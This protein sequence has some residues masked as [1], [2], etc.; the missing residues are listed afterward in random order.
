[1]WYAWTEQ[2]CTVARLRYYESLLD[3]SER[4]RLARLAH[5]HLRHEYLLTR[6]LCRVSLSRYAGVAPAQWRFA[7]GRYGKPRIEWP[8]QQSL[9]FNL[10]NSRDLVACVVARDIDVGIDV[11]QIDR[12]VDQQEIA[13]SHFSATELRAF[14]ALAPERQRRRF[15]ELWTLKECYLKACGSGLSTALE[16]F[17]FDLDLNGA[18]TLTQDTS[19]T[20]PPAAW[21]FQLFSPDEQHVLAVGLRRPSG[22][23]W[24][25]HLCPT[26]P[27]DDAA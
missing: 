13:R 20:E 24:T 23:E 27:D 2:C 22:P 1:M 4:Q 25:I 18:P 14:L 15:Y 10:S 17:S 7:A 5:A 6:A 12:D 21:Q 19:A 16:T 26:T 9:Q 3:D 8:P 11:E